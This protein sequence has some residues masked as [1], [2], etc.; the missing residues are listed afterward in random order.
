MKAK[1]KGGYNSR[2][3]NSSIRTSGIAPSII[4][5]R[6]Y[7]TICGSSSPLVYVKIDSYILMCRNAGQDIAA[8]FGMEGTLRCPNYAKYCTENKRTCAYHCNKNGICINGMC[9]CTGATVLTA[10]CIDESNLTTTIED[11]AGLTRSIIIDSGD[12]LN[13][14]NSRLSRTKVLLSRSEGGS[15][16]G[17]TSILYTKKSIN[18]KCML[19]T[20][21]DK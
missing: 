17:R 10:T 16:V 7:L 14:V 21:F 20:Y 11:T 3:F 19:G 4:N 1:E 13:L 9:L 5:F 18:T 12:V 6:C 8:P 2:C 15:A